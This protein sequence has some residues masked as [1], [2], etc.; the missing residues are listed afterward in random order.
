MKGGIYGRNHFFRLNVVETWRFFNQDIIS[1]L[2]I[3]EVQLKYG[4]IFRFTL[5]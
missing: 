5:N 4:A 3:F 1:T 2:P